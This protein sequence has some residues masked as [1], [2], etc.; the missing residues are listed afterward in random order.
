MCPLIFKNTNFRHLKAEEFNKTFCWIKIKWGINYYLTR[1][2]VAHTNYSLVCCYIDDMRIL[3]RSQHVTWVREIVNKC[4]IVFEVGLENREYGC[5]DPWRWPRGTLSPQKLAL[6]SPTSSGRSVGIVRSR[7]QAVE[8]VCN[9]YWF[10]KSV[11]ECMHLNDKGG[12]EKLAIRRI[13]GTETERMRRGWSKVLLKFLLIFP[14][15][16]FFSIKSFDLLW[17]ELLKTPLNDEQ[18]GKYIVQ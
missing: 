5:K 1:N 17:K 10:W 9:L 18:R 8:F 2:S 7:T 12:H 13:G 15:S 3:P 16:L 6:T 14:S 4:S 11:L